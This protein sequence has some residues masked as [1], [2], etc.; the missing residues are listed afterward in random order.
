MTVKPLYI[1]KSLKELKEKADSTSKL[2]NGQNFKDGIAKLTSAARDAKLTGDQERAFILYIRAANMIIDEKKKKNADKNYIELMFGKTLLEC[3]KTSEE[4]EASLKDRYQLKHHSSMNGDVPDMKSSTPKQ[5]KEAVLKTEQVNGFKEE[6][7]EYTIEAKDV[8]EYLKNLGDKKE[9]SSRCL[10]IDIRD[11]QDFVQSKMTKLPCREDR[12]HYINIPQAFLRNINS[13]SELEKT[14]QIDSRTFIKNRKSCDKIIIMDYDS[15]NLETTTNR[16][17]T[18]IHKLLFDLS[19][20]DEKPE[21]PPLVLKGGFEEW[22]VTYGT[23]VTD[24]NYNPIGNSS[25]T[26][27]EIIRVPSPDINA[28]RFGDEVEES[29]RN[30]NISNGFSEPEKMSNEETVPSKPWNKSSPGGAVAVNPV[31]GRQSLPVLVRGDKRED[32]VNPPRT[33]AVVPD[34]SSKPN[35]PSTLKPFTPALKTSSLEEEKFKEKK[36]KELEEEM[37]RM[38]QSDSIHNEASESSFGEIGKTIPSSEV[39]TSVTNNEVFDDE[40]SMSVSTPVVIP[41]SNSTV[42]MRSSDRTFSESKESSFKSSSGGMS[43]SYSSPNI[44]KDIQRIEEEEEEATVPKD[45]AYSS[46]LTTS[47]SYMPHFDRK[48][49]PKLDRPITSFPAK[50]RDFNSILG[51]KPAATT[52]LKNLLNTCFMNSV[53]QCLANT[54]VLH[55]YFVWKQLHYRHI[56]RN[57]KFGSGGELVEELAELIKQMYQTYRFISPKDFRAAVATHMP[58]FSGNEQQDSHEFLTMLLEKLHYDLN[59]PQIPTPPAITLPDNM[60]TNIA[61]R[62]FWENHT[63]RNNSVFSRNFEGLLLSTLTCRMCNTKSDSFEVF[64]CLSLPIPSGGR[65]HLTDVLRQFTTSE[66]LTGEASWDCTFCKVKREAIKR[67]QLCR[68][69]NI[70]VIHLKR[71]VL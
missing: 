40:I 3:V 57:S 23:C 6:K 36:M 68:L 25:K 56:N 17:L 27:S 43:R 14:L 48:T 33:I 50:H 16:C 61:I 45:T 2:H 44:V 55:D 65:C 31:I 12:I 7:M 66:S 5:E 18:K 46:S 52:G 53:L 34:R 49:K 42:K 26:S 71:L 24:R 20:P 30:S 60:E 59:Q 28:Y 67:I 64:S 58:V 69:P 11:S 41:S 37:Q 15:A 39:K 4:M 63:S 22:I 38:K 54:P 21:K 1:A 51:H 9:P 62:K 47:I 70:L 8:Y 35:L 19:R 32:K 29:V 10:I 13:G